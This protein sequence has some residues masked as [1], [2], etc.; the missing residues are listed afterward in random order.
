M[1]NPKRIAKSLRP[2]LLAG[3]AALT[4]SAC[5][6]NRGQMGATDHAGMSAAQGQT[7]LA[8]LTARY[9]ANPR[10][11]GVVIRYAAALIPE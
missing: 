1:F 6:S 5:A 2:L 11:R 3:V 7:A 9:R 4:L 10:D 8:D